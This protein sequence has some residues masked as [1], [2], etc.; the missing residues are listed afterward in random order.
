MKLLASAKAAAAQEALGLQDQLH[1]SYQRAMANTLAAMGI[2]HTTEDSSSGYAVDIGI[3][4]LRVVLEADGPSHM[5]R[6]GGGRRALGAT[7]MKKRHLE[8]MGWRV[9]NVTFQ[10]WNRLTSE[11]EREAFLRMR[12]RGVKQQQQE[13]QQQ[14]QAQ[15]K[16][17]LSSSLPRPH[18]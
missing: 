3:P 9:V 11:Q 10:Q 12:L 14:Q 8:L 13:G 4:Q 6:V 17:A 15:G 2:L 1:S 7:L 5:S 16:Q 18:S